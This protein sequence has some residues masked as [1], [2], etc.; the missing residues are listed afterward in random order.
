MKNFELINFI[1][2]IKKQKTYLEKKIFKIDRII[3]N[4]IYKF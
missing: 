4:R 2:Q 1:F 3:T